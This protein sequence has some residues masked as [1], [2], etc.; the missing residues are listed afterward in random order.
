MIPRKN[1]KKSVTFNNTTV[2]LFVSKYSCFGRCAHMRYLQCFLTTMYGTLPSM[3]M[4]IHLRARMNLW[5]SRIFSMTGLLAIPRR[6]LRLFSRQ[7]V[8]LASICH[9]RF[10]GICGQKQIKTSGLLM[11]KLHLLYGKSSSS[12]LTATVQ[13]RLPVFLHRKEY[14]RQLLMPTP[15]EGMQVTLTQSFITGENKLLTIFLKKLNMQVTP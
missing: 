15:R 5:H 6:R 12:A 3:I 4:L 13:R 8:C 14:P 9:L 2:T 1:I 10:M 11:K 7:R